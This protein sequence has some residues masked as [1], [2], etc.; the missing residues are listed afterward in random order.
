LFGK[1][2]AENKIKTG[3]KCPTEVLVVFP[4]EER[5]EETFNTAKRLRQRGFNVEMYH[6][7]GKISR[8]LRYASRKGIPYVWFPPFEE[9]A[10]HEVKD[11]ATGT[12]AT[13]DPNT[14]SPAND[15][16]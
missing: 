4:T 3:P 1:L 13:A 5:R 14:W 15:G 8:Q 10:G 11:M 16:G 7:P 9:G 6:S 2:I 12:Q